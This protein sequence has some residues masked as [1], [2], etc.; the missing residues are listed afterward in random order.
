MPRR[1]NSAARDG[2]VG[3]GRLVE[4]GAEPA[5]AGVDAQRPARL[6]VDEGQLADVDERVLARVGDLEG[7]DRVAAGDLGQR[8]R[9]QSRGPRKSETM[10]TTPAVR[11]RWRRRARSA[12]A[13]EVGAA[14]LLGR[15][16]RDAPGGGRACRAGRRPAAGRSRGRPRR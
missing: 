15:F 16:G 8:P 4:G 1:R 7:D 5:I 3:R 14:A 12:R 2:A 13:G 11:P 10:T 9:R 6:G